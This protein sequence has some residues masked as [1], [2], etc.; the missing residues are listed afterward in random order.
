MRK[1]ELHKKKFTII[2]AARSGIAAAKLLKK[3]NASLFISESAP[4][5]KIKYLHELQNLEIPFE[6]NG[7]TARALETDVIILSPGVPGTIPIIIEAQRRGIPIV[8]ELEFASWF[9]SAC[10]IAVTGTNGKTTTTAL[11]GQIF[12]DA[13]WE[14]FIGGNIGNAFSNFV[15]STTS[16]SIVILETSS[17]QLDWTEK[18]H[19]HISIVTNITADHLDRYENNINN[20]VASKTK[21]LSQQT[22]RDIFIYNV[23]DEWTR[24]ILASAEAKKI[25]CT[26]FSSSKRMNRGAFISNN[27]IV[28]SEQTNEQT[29]IETDKILITGKHNVENAMAATLAARA[30]G[31]SASQISHTL[32]TFPGVEHRIEF[33][34]E[35]DGVQYYNDS[36]A[37]NV[38]S[39]EKALQ[40]F[41]LHENKIVLLLG[42]REQAEGNDYT[43]VAQLIAK[44]VRSIIALGES[45]EKIARFFSSTNRTVIASSMLEAVAAATQESVA[46]DIILLSPACKSFDWFEDFEH[47]GKVYKDLVHQL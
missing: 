8:S 27:S 4:E 3:L 46:G 13:G 39:L 36:K 28:V 23:D 35:K 19:P 7:H 43:P 32:M 24:T 47:R 29:I 30:M 12:K 15:L 42:G 2:G 45:A 18:F 31:V 5:Q 38:D 14:T 41:P 34:R 16:K 9:C 11:L 6:T 44:N 37:T 21:I 10:I 22:V 26:G 40:S 17:Y 33:V 25:K 1:E 20:Y